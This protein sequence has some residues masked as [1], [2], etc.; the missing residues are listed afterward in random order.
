MGCRIVRMIFS[1]RFYF[2]SS[3]SLLSIMETLDL[4][5]FPQQDP[6][7]LYFVLMLLPH[8]YPPTSS[9][10]SFMSQNKN[11]KDQLLGLSY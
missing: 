9:F 2:P 7:C 10:I 5:S 11:K 6:T 1:L 3:A 8:P 4:L